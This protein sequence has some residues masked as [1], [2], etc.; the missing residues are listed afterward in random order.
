MEEARV[1]MMRILE[2]TEMESAILL[3][4]ANKMD[5]PNAIS[6][7]E[8]RERLLLSRYNRPYYIQPTCGLSGDGLIEGLE[9]LSVTLNEK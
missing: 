9:W 6:V 8:I 2:D 5:L 3:V 1:E 7:E 4:L